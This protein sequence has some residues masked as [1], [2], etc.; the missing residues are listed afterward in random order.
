MSESSNIAL[1]RRLYDSGAAPEVMVEIIA[2]DL[3]WDIT[4]GFPFG[5]VYHG[6]DS[7]MSDFFGRLTPLVDSWGAQAEQYFPSGD[8]HVFV[9]GHYHGVKGDEKAD[10]RFIHLWT[11]RDGKLAAMKQAADSHLAQQLL[12]NG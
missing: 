1:V 8:D 2:S 10:V 12:A 6:R 4:P 11:V 5:G 7:M 3:V 9:I